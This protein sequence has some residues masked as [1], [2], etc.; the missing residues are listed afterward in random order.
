MLLSDPCLKAG[1]SFG[2]LRSGD[3]QAFSGSKMVEVVLL[4]TELWQMVWKDRVLAYHSLLPNSVAVTSNTSMCVIQDAASR[5]LP[6][7]RQKASQA[8]NLNLILLCFP[9]PRRSG[10]KIQMPA[11]PHSCNQR[12]S[13]ISSL[14]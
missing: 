7:V 13:A 14:L 2:I 9:S 5:Q 11:L 6:Y 1:G 3:R 12:R 4:L 8:R 10:L